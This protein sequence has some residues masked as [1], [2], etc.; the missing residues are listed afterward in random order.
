M[1]KYDLDAIIAVLIEKLKEQF[2]LTT[3][4]NTKRVVIY[5]IILSLFARTKFLYS[6][7]LIE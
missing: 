5:L 6:G 7:K 2:I 1:S 4:L 3:I